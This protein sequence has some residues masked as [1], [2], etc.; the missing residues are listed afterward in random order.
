[1]VAF[2]ASTAWR[3]LGDNADFFINEDEDRSLWLYFVPDPSGN[4]EWILQF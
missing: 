1:M 3:G 4:G 2:S